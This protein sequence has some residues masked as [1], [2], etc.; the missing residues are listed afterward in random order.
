MNCLICSSNAIFYTKDKKRNYFLCEPCQLIF[1]P[2]SELISEADERSRY[3]LH[4]NDEQNLSYANYLD[5]ICHHIYPLIEKG[6]NGLDFGSGKS[7][8][9]SDLLSQ[10]ELTIDSYD[11]FFH[12]NEEI[13][14]KKYDFIILSEVI[15]HLRDPLLTMKN[16]RSILSGDGKLFIKTNL[17]EFETQNFLTWYY[18]NDPTHIQ[19]FSW[20]ALEELGR[21]F[22]LGELKRT[23]LKDLYYFSSLPISS[24]K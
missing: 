19:F 7:K 20:H 5:E 24:L 16:I 22:N 8:I 15:E 2:R 11:I 14:L 13:W 21:R 18:K 6:K 1:V 10:R 12:P 3:E 4:D 17:F 9:M 23:K